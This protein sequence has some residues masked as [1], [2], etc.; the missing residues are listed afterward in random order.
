ME[1]VPTPIS[2]TGRTVAFSPHYRSLRAQLDELAFRTGR[3]RQPEGEA[4]IVCHHLQNGPVVVHRDC[5]PIARRDRLGV[6]R[7]VFASLGRGLQVT[8]RRRRSVVGL[9]AGTAGGG[10]SLDIYDWGPVW[11]IKPC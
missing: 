11:T 7:D 3:R 8:G 4:L 6:L 9:S 1:A 10:P 2:T 5:P